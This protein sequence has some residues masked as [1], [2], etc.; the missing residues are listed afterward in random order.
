MSGETTVK[1]QRITRHSHPFRFYVVLLKYLGF[2]ALC[3][4]ITLW[5]FAESSR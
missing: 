5:E 1:R 2:A 3:A 4:I